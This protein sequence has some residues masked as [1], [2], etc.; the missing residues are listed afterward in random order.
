M[1]CRWCFTNDL[2]EAFGAGNEPSA[3]WL[4]A[5]IDYFD[6]TKVF[7]FDSLE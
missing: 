6:G 7:Y 3:S 1:L 5:N 2:T 4:D